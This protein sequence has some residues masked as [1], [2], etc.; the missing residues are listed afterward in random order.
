MQENAR[1]AGRIWIGLAGTTHT[2][3]LVFTL[4]SPFYPPPPPSW[5]G[6][7]EIRGRA[8]GIHVSLPLTGALS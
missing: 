4:R 6:S 8:H 5:E 1:L 3:M 2:E 7:R